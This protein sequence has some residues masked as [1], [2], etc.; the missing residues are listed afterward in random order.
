[1]EGIGAD[2]HPNVKTHEKMA[3]KFEAALQSDLGW[4]PVKP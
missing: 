1:V 4:K 3:A 2:Y